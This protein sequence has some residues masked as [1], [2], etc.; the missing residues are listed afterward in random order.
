MAIGLRLEADGAQVYAAA[1]I[2]VSGAEV[3]AVGVVIGVGNGRNAVNSRLVGG[4]VLVVTDL[5]LPF[6]IGAADDVEVDGVGALGGTDAACLLIAI[7]GD[8]A[9]GGIAEDVALR[10][11]HG[12]VGA[13]SGFAEAVA[14]IGE[15]GFLRAGFE[16]AERP[17][18]DASA[19]FCAEEDALRLA[20]GEAGADAASEK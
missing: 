3:P 16:Q 6:E 18:R 2:L 10:A 11:E 15:I 13:G 17:S 5:T 8:E 12:E 19:E 7:D 9:D 4:F 14:G 20:I 1:E